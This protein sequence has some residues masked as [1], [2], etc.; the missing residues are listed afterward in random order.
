MKSLLSPIFL[1]LAS[2]ILWILVALC[3]NCYMRS[4]LWTYKIVHNEWTISYL[5]ICSKSYFYLIISNSQFYKEFRDY[6][7]EWLELYVTN[8]HCSKLYA[9]FLLNIRYI[10]I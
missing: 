3:E 5:Q 8:A 9:D 2:Q 1:M 10:N 4:Y 7:W 6:L